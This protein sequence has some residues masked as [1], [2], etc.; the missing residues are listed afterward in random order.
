MT[1]NLHAHIFLYI[2][3]VANMNVFTY[4]PSSED[5]LKK[6]EVGHINENKL[7]TCSHY[8]VSV[9]KESRSY[10]IVYNQ[11]RERERKVIFSIF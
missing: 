11:M 7:I 1:I 8:C 4:L 2:M 3:K 6:Q 9:Y 10:L 5:Y